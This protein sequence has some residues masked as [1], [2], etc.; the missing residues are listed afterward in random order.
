MA[1]AGILF[2]KDG[3]LF[4][5]EATFA[6][7]CAAVARELAN[8][9]EALA[10]TL[11]EAVGFDLAGGVF[12]T[13]SVVIAG[14]AGDI[15]R[16]VAATLQVEADELLAR[17]IDSLFQR[18][19]SGSAILFSGVGD[20][21]LSLAAAGIPV[22]MATNDAEANGRSHAMLAGIDGHFRFFAGYDSGHGAKPGPGMILAFAS[23][24][25]ADVRNVVMVGDSLH[26]MHAARAAGAI[27]VAVTT[28]LASRAILEPHAD[29][30]IDD[31]SLLPALPPVAERLD[32]LR[33]NGD[34]R[35]LP[36]ASKPSTPA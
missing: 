31:V 19:S 16:A 33:A 20:L 36:L 22:G 3:T 28:G 9:D 30:V 29:Y 1:A 12:T 7:A 2:D 23:M 27:G 26:D 8:G 17:R 32:Q 11:C 18:H 6:P 13:D 4:D 5:F 14:T 35:S 25:G 15:A 34:S 24:I 21:L 10:A